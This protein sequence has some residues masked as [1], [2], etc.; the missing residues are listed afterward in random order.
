MIED[1]NEDRRRELCE[2]FR[3]SLAKPV[4]ERY[5]DEEGLPEWGRHIEIPR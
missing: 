1:E 3:Q 2:R 5:F 4:S